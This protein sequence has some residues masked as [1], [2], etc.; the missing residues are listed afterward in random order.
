MKRGEIWLVNLEPALGVEIKKNRPCATV[1][2]DTIGALPLKVVAPLTDGKD[3]YRSVPWMVMVVPDKYNH[4][5]KTSAIDLFQVRCVAEERLIHKL[6][7]I[8]T[9]FF[10]GIAKALKTVFS[11]S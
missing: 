5:D 4:L 1:N 2:D 11:L 6:G 10:E 9:G 8:Q 3:R 7:T